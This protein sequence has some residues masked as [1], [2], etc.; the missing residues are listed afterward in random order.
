MAPHHNPP[1]GC[2]VARPLTLPARPVGRGANGTFIAIGAGLVAAQDRQERL[3][4]AFGLGGPHARDV[5]KLGQ[6]RGAVLGDL[7]QGGLGAGQVLAGAIG[8]TGKGQLQYVGTP[9]TCI[10]CHQAGFNTAPNHVA[11]RFTRRP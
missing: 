11:S 4:K 1:V 5:V 9:A 2:E 3:A 8:A 10:S 7:A 6:G